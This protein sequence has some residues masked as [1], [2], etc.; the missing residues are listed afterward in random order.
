M[1]ILS[2]CG[3]AAWIGTA[4][5]V[6]SAVGTLALAVVAVF[7]HQIWSW[8]RSPSLSVQYEN[9]PPGAIKTPIQ[10]T[11][12]TDKLN[13]LEVREY[14]SYW[15]RLQIWN[16]GAAAAENVEVFAERL[17]RARA[18]GELEPVEGF[19]PGGLAWSDTNTSIL[20][21]IPAHAYRYCCLV[22]VVRP[23]DR[24]DLGLEHHKSLPTHKTALSVDKVV[25]TFSSDHLL[26]PG[27]YF[28]HLQVAA[29]NAP[30]V[31]AVAKVE[32]TGDWVDELDEMLSKGIRVA[33]EGTA[34]S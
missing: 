2:D 14:P 7:Q 3:A 28:V 18:N 17:F 15:V 32:L 10:V 27:T 23:S 1:A 22:H 21:R 31:H 13:E 16:K 24:K 9:K 29:S 34:A 19:V 30:L 26:S 11:R 20:P 25:K 6:L 8:F 33:V 4:A 5:T 12:P